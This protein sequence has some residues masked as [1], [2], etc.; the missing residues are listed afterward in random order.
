MTSCQALLYQLGELYK[1]TR[2]TGS[3]GWIWNFLWAQFR[4]TNFSNNVIFL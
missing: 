4:V 3:E 2:S 1:R